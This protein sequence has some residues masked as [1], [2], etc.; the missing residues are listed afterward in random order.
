MFIKGNDKGLP[1]AQYAELVFEAIRQNRLYV[2]EGTL[3]DAAI[4][5]RTEDILARRNPEAKG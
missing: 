1:P 2:V 5:Q 4:R 3:F